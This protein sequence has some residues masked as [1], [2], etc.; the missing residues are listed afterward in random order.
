MNT[1]LL[2]SGAV[3]I[4][5]RAIRI[6]SEPIQFELT[7]Y[8]PVLRALLVIL[9]FTLAK[10]TAHVAF[11]VRHPKPATANGPLSAPVIV[12]PWYENRYLP[13]S[14]ATEHVAASSSAA[15]VLPAPARANGNSQSER[16]DVVLH[17]ASTEL[18]GYRPCGRRMLRLASQKINWK[19]AL[20]GWRRESPVERRQARQ[21]QSPTASV[22]ARW[23]C[24]QEAGQAL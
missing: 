5:V 4:L 17:V 3:L 14:V 20:T 10:E 6:A 21:V 16:A 22:L 19:I 15:S 23:R 2:P 18:E 24:L 9:P 8:V 11:A 1:K 7:V 12:T 13:C